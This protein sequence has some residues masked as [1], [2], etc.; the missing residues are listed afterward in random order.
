MPRL[1]IKYPTPEQ[2]KHIFKAEK[3]LS[4]AGITF[5]VGC[6]LDEGTI[7]CKDWELDW[8]LKGEV[9]EGTMDDK[10]P[11]SFEE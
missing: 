7:T 10:T 6:G 4:R 5:D 8:S 1:L 2:M 9:M 11:P 3:E